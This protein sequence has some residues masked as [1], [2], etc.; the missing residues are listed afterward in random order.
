MGEVPARRNFGPKP[1]SA[2]AATGRK[3]V[4]GGMKERGENFKGG[5]DHARFP[6]REDSGRLRGQGEPSQ[7]SDDE[8]LQRLN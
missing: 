3:G 2:L 4:C 8:R 1:V 5:P 7:N 6:K